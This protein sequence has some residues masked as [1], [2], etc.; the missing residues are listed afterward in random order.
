M[1]VTHHEF[2]KLR[3]RELPVFANINLLGKCNVDC[4]FCLGKDID[5]VFNQFDQT[6]TPVSELINL[7]DFLTACKQ[8]RIN[9]IYVTGQ[10]TDALLYRY[11]PELISHIQDD[12][13]LDAGFRTNG[14]LMHKHLG[15]ANV[16]RRNIG[17]SIHSL[18]GETNYTIMGRKDI[19]RWDEIIPQLPRVRVSV[20]LNRHNESEFDDLLKFIASFSNVAYIQV[21][22]ICTDTRES[23]LLP[24]VEAYERVFQRYASENKLC[25]RFYGS[26]EFMV[27]GKRVCFWRTVKTTIGSM[28]YYT[29]GTINDGYFVIEGYAQAR[30]AP[31]ADPMRDAKLEGYWRKHLPV[32]D[33]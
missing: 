12:F 33:P 23:Y 1:P 20:V 11:L 29:D 28:N 22:R 8:R 13:G 16:V 19:P 9:R 6:K 5:G 18:S 4:Y 30:G 14:Y 24:D 7:D 10:N 27:H 32:I 17:L 3:E 21:R 25:G 26:E 31:D 2:D 15:L